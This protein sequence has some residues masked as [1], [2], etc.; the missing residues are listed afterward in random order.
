MLTADNVK[1]IGEPITADDGNLLLAFFAQYPS[2][3]V[4]DGGKV[5]D[6][7]EDNSDQLSTAVS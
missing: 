7:V 2:G 6:T 1:F 4:V 5:T 3:N